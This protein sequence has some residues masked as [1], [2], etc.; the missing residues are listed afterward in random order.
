MCFAPA[1][2]LLSALFSGDRTLRLI[3]AVCSSVLVALGSALAGCGGEDGTVNPTSGTAT[4]DSVT[5][6]GTTT[7]A[8]TAP[9]AAISGTPA[10]SAVVGQS[11]SFTPTASDSDGGTLHFSIANAPSWATFNAS[12][13]QLSGSPKDTSVGTTSNI[14][15]T[16]A[17]GTA[18]ASLP[19]FSINVASTPPV[20]S[21][22]T[23]SVTSSATVTW[24][25]PTE[26]TNGTA[27]TDL[28]GYTIYYG[29]SASSMTQTIQVKSATATSYV[30]TGLTSGTWYFAVASYTSGG[31]ESALS[32]VS[33]KTI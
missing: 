8:S 17:D 7:T 29:T 31:T 16:V 1:A 15:I 3:R 26:N 19:A 14:V 28:A 22:A 24:T 18:T 30:I 13:G 5:S 12:T 6:T 4:A 9:T 27:L 20:T 21:P 32:A 2:H 10:T 25:A 11:Y 23:P 33:S